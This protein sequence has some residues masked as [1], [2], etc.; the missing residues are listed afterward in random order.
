MEAV[1]MI[2]GFTLFIIGLAALMVTYL[3][4]GFN[5]GGFI[6]GICPTCGDRRKIKKNSLGGYSL[7]DLD[8][9]KAVEVLCSGCGNWMKVGHT[10]H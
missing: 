3:D 5:R 1:L 6:Y 2:V 10:A 8:K 7:V 9:G 4:G